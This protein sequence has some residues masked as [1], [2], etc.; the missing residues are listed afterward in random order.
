MLSKEERERLVKEQMDKFS[1]KT[2]EWLMT[3][4]SV[5][6][7]ADFTKDSEFYEWL[8]CGN[9]LAQRGYEYD[10]IYCFWHKEGEGLG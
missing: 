10:H 5:L 4:F 2:D 6:S 3:A 1:D 9:L 7:I 8:A